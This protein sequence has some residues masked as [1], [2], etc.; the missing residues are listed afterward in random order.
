MAYV[1]KE[2]SAANRPKQKD[3]GGDTR[4]KQFL[5][6]GDVLSLQTRHMLILHQWQ[7]VI[8]YEK[9]GHVKIQRISKKSQRESGSKYTLAHGLIGRQKRTNW[10]SITT[11]KI[12]LSGLHDLENLDGERQSPASSFRPK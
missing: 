1:K 2:I 9:K 8:Y 12:L 7:P 3:Y 6:G 11:K 10:S 4:T 5:A